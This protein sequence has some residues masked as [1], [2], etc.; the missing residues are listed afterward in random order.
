MNRESA[1]FGGTLRQGYAHDLKSGER[2][3]DSDLALHPDNDDLR[4]I[5]SD[6]DVMY[7]VDASDGNN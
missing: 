2:L 1:W 4:G 6:G 7:I 3:P 5:W